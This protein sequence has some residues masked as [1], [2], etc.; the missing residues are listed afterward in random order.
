M[1]IAQVLLRILDHVTLLGLHWRSLHHGQS[2]D[3]VTALRQQI[4]LLIG[5]CWSQV[6]DF[7]KFNSINKAVEKC[8]S[9]AF[10]RV[11]E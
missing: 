5:Y 9:K 6:S 1:E 4:L 10:F 8:N 3:H 2:E 7:E 11:C